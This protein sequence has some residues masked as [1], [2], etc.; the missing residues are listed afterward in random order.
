MSSDDFLRLKNTL[1]SDMA[2]YIRQ[3]GVHP[4]MIRAM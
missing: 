4:D 1:A 3:Y 2:A